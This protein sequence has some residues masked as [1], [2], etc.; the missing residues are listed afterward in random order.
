MDTLHMVFTMAEL[1]H[2]LIDEFGNN[3]GLLTITWYM[4]YSQIVSL[5]N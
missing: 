2:Y 4:P 5:P 1:W 3:P